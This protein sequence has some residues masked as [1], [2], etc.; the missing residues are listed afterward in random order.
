MWPTESVA[1]L[2]HWVCNDE[3]F[4]KDTSGHRQE[5][6]RSPWV[7]PLRK[8]MKLKTCT[9]GVPRVPAKPICVSPFA[10]G[11]RYILGETLHGDT[12][13]IDPTGSDPGNVF[14]SLGMSA[15]FN[16]MRRVTDA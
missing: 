12:C 11:E 3:P 16:T 2:E 10:G 1:L 8:N 13:D 7:I 4:I 5:M 9:S 15:L 6:S 14:G